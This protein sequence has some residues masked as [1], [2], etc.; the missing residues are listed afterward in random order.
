M[1]AVRFLE[2]V[3]RG[4]HADALIRNPG[5]LALSPRD[6]RLTTKLVFGILRRREEL[7]FYVHNFSKLPFNKLDPQVL[8]ILR[9]GL[10][11]LEALR[12]PSRAAVNETVS[13]CRKLGKTSAAGFVNA[14]LRGFLRSKPPLPTGENPKS[15]SIRYSHPEW[16]VSRYLKRYGAKTSRRLMQR[17]NTA[18][19]FAFWVNSFK[20]TLKELCRRLDRSG[21]EYSVYRALENCLLVPSSFSQHRLY[22]AGL[23]FFMDIASQEVAHMLDVRGAKTVGD[24]CAA[25]GGKSFLLASRIEKETHLLCS[26]AGLERLRRMKK[27]ASLYE[28]QGLSYV[29][30]DQQPSAPFRP[31]FDSILVDVPCSGLGTI[32]SN[33]DIRWKIKE[34]DLSRFHERQ[35][36][37][38]TG[39]FSALK[40]GGELVYSTCSTEPEE[41]EQVVSLLLEKKTSGRLVGEYRTTFPQDHPG[42]CFF[43][44]RIRHA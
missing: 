40:P 28:I 16:L 8:W 27:R 23:G 12:I 4:R 35:L 39:A 29:N 38:L 13:L 20:I 42:D 6:R 31:R 32:R 44:A 9:C 30:A 11:Q 34:A 22:R 19:S 33:P 15:L 18:P 21:I 25:P 10:Y 41:N 3:E 1:V 37:I 43:A 17:N 7:D 5:F 14:I 24:F 2:A 26:D 36:D